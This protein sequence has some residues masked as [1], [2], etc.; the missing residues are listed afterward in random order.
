MSNSQVVFAEP[1]D[2]VKSCCVVSWASQS[3]VSCGGRRQS[4]YVKSQLLGS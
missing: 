3:K 1:H 2:N 4:C